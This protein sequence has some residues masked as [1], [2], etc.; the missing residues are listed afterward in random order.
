MHI[1]NVRQTYARNVL[2]QCAVLETFCILNSSALV[3]KNLWL[4]KTGDPHTISGCQL[5]KLTL[6]GFFFGIFCCSLES[7][8]SI[9]GMKR[10]LVQTCNNTWTQSNL[11]I[12]VEAIDMEVLETMRVI[13]VM[14]RTVQCITWVNCQCP[15]LVVTY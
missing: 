13:R 2:W 4:Y 14:R 9:L 7:N 11:L 6:W 3:G 12:L 5:T 8:D 1:L 10:E 15:V